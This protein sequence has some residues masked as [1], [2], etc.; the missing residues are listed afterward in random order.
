V[1]S[2]LSPLLTAMGVE[3]RVGMGAVR[4]S[5]GRMTTVDEVDAALGR[6]AGVAGMRP[7]TSA[8]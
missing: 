7:T 6:F 2:G 5:L 3:P 1:T 4:L 8:G